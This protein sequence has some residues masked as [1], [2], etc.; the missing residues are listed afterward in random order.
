MSVLVKSEMLTPPKEEFIYLKCS[1]CD[2]PTRHKVLAT[3]ASH[4]QDDEGYVDLW[5]SHHLIQCQG[6]MN[7]TFLKETQFFEDWDVDSRTGEQ[8]MPT[9]RFQYPELSEGREALPESHLLPSKVRKIYDETHA[10]LNSKMNIMVGFGVRAIVE[11]VCKDKNISG[12]N[13][14]TKID[15]LANSGHI[16]TDGATILH[17]LR[18]M[19]N[20]AVHEIKEHKI[21]ELNAAIDVTDYLLKGVYVLPKIA[22]KLPKK[23]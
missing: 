6:C 19:G 1:T 5:E 14:A 23:S 2:N 10:A 12:R 7:T 18:F 15:N 11:A 3:N 21:E 9:E 20:E 16:T 22:E 17:N 13:L 8:F 4:W